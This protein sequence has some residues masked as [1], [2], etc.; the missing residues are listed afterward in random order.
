[1]NS[2]QIDNTCFRFITSEDISPI[3]SI[4][5]SE[6]KEVENEKKRRP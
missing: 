6:E 4:K 3:P 5:L 1:M 2:D